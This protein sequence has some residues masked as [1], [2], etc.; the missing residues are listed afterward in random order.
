MNKASLK[1]FHSPIRKI[2]TA[3]IYL[4]AI[5]QQIK[6]KN[7]YLNCYKNNQPGIIELKNGT[8]IEVQGKRCIQFLNSIFFNHIYGKP[9]Q[10][11]TLVDIGANKG[12][13]S[14]FFGSQLKGTDFKIFSYEPHPKT[15]ELLN[16]NIQHNHLGKNIYTFQKCVSGAPVATQ[17]FFVARESFDYSMFNE[18]G[19][20]EEIT[21][22]N[23]TLQEIFEQNN[24]TAIDLLKLN[25]EGAEY[26]ILMKTPLNY[27]LKIREIRMEYHNFELDGKVYDLNPL[28]DYLRQNNF[29]ITN[30]L[31]YAE[32][33]G[34]IWFENNNKLP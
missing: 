16:K 23:I 7:T 33:H 34:I 14:V 1:N 24:I 28:V 26:E 12:L 9:N 30:H 3:W 32:E 2:K 25:C 20:E 22:E 6:N 21:V 27:L 17:T 4:N 29:T 11:K 31:P 8:K 5:L 15:F 13:F 10:Q 18:Y 19:S